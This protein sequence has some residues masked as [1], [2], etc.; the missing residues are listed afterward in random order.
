LEPGRVQGDPDGFPERISGGRLADPGSRRR[1]TKDGGT[2]PL[3]SRDGSRLLY[4]GTEGVVSLTLLSA[5]ELR[6]D[7]PQVAARSQDSDEIIGFDVAPEGSSVLIQRTADR[8]MLRRDL[9][10][11][12]GW[13]AV[14]SASR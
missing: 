1:L 6:F 9:R 4:Q 2:L 3:W 5:A 7:A 13:G 12:P 11:W 10:L 8:L 14:V